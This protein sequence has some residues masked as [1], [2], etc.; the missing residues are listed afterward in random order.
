MKSNKQK[1]GQGRKS[2]KSRLPLTIPNRMEKPAFKMQAHAA[3]NL[4]VNAVNVR[5]LNLSP[6]LSTFPTASVQCRFFESYRITRISYSILSLDNVSYQ[7]GGNSLE[8]LYYYR[9]VN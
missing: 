5:Q 2:Q 7:Q 4:T 9:V 6:S 8:L 3:I 1:R